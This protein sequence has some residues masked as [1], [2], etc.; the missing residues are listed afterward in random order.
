MGWTFELMY[1]LS[2]KKMGENIVISRV[3]KGNKKG[4]K[5]PGI[6]RLILLNGG[7]EGH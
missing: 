3:A 1:Y 7:E 5:D 2:S 4:R 6:L